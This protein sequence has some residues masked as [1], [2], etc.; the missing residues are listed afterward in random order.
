M[1][2]LGGGVVERLDRGRGF[3]AQGLACLLCHGFSHAR[4]LR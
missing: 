3:P 2:S 4:E 1:A